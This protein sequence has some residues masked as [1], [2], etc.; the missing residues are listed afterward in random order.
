MESKVDIWNIYGNYIRRNRVVR[1]WILISVLSGLIILL[2]FDFNQ[3][4]VYYLN[5]PDRLTLERDGKIQEIS[6][7]HISAVSVRPIF[8]GLKLIKVPDTEKNNQVSE[9]ILVIILNLL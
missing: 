4:V 2:R 6:A 8:P 1:L 9:Y 5:N 3:S 7:T